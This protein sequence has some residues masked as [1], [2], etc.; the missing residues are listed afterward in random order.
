MAVC[1]YAERFTVYLFIFAVCISG[2]E[3]HEDYIDV[4]TITRAPNNVTLYLE[5]VK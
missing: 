3:E 2:Q 1:Y 4:S 5:F